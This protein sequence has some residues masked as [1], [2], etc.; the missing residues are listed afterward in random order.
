MSAVPVT[1]KILAPAAPEELPDYIRYA[2]K[3]E[4][5][6]IVEFGPNTR[7]ISSAGGPI[8]FPMPWQVYV[9]RPRANSMKFFVRTEPLSSINDTLYFPHIS[10]MY[11]NC[12]PCGGIPLRG[13]VGGDG[14]DDVERA[15]SHINYFWTTGF[16]GGFY[17]STDGKYHGHPPAWDPGGNL[18]PQDMVDKLGDQFWYAD[19]FSGVKRDHPFFGWIENLKPEELLKWKWKAAAPVKTIVPEAKRLRARKDAHQAARNRAAEEGVGF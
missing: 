8:R 9:C 10:N 12:E 4:G 14:S 17:T 19:G 13:R 11:R 1:S 16:N 5:I 3:K 7:L 15:V 18:M 2:N 6:Y